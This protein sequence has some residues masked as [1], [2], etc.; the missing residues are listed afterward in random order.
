MAMAADDPSPAAVMTWALGLVAFPAAQTPATLVSPVWS[1][2]TQPLSWTA[3][4]R[5]VS[6]APL[7][8]RSGRTKTADLGTTCPFASST[9]MRW[10]PSTTRRATSSSTMPMAAAMSFS[11]CSAARV[12]PSAKRTTSSDHCR[13]SSAWV[14]DSGEPPRTP[15]GWSRTS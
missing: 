7:G 15:S 6:R 4:P 8:A 10:S 5:S 13:M 2:V 9:P 14:R 12:A 3:Q 1:T 11:R